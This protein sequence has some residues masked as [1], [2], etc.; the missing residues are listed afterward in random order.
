MYRSDTGKVIGTIQR[1]MIDKRTGQVAYAVMTFGGFL[2]FGE[3]HFPIPWSSLRYDQR[4]GGYV[5]DITANQLRDAP[6]YEANQIDISDLTHKELP[7]LIEKAHLA[8]LR[9]PGTEGTSLETRSGLDRAFRQRTETALQRLR[10]NI[11]ESTVVSALAA[12]TDLG[13]LARA[14]A[15]SIIADPATRDL[16]PFAAALARGAE[17]REQLLQQAGGALSAEGV[18]KILHISRQAVDKRRTA[19]SLLAV[20]QAGAWRYPAFQFAN[21]DP[22]TALK[23]I[24]ELLDDPNGWSTLDFLL[25]PDTV[26]EGHSPMQA[27]QLGPAWQER[28]LRLVRAQQGDG[29]A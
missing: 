15:D 7:S 22:P 6:S 18:G 19:K 29:F 3:Q 23:P 16:D 8:L 14:L 17:H 2:G 12:P 13:V 1:L 20:K 21:G 4:W 5:T 27:L 24:I 9:E 26:L 10:Q 28:V 11:D 25:T